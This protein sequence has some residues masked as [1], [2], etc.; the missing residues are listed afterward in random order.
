MSVIKYLLLI[1]KIITSTPLKE[2]W[3]GSEKI[4]AT[5]TRLLTKSDIANILR[6]RTVE[7]VFASP[8]N[9]LRWIPIEDCFA[10]WKNE[11]KPHL[12]DDSNK[13]ILEDYPDG[14]AF[15]ASEWKYDS[16]SSIVLLE[17]HH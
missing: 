7:F 17:S 14:L 12:V 5:K 15:V 3:K 8:G 6:S 11:I 2:L 4:N 9:T 16:E 1:E 10:A 13:I